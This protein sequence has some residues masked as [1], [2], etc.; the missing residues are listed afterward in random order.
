MS[1]FGGKADIKS[2]GAMFALT[3]S[4]HR[5]RP[6]V[7]IADYFGTKVPVWALL[8]MPNYSAAAVYFEALAMWATHDPERRA[9]FVVC[10]V[11]YRAL[12]KADHSKR[13]QHSWRP[14]QSRLAA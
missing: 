10:A 2:K 4:G 14:P 3:Q 13:A 5:L 7:L 8:G 1:A 6:V 12:A 11:K 9:H